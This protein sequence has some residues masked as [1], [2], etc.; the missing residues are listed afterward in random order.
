ML[1]KVVDQKRK[2]AE[3]GELMEKLKSVQLNEETLAKMTSISSVQTKGLKR[4]AQEEEWLRRLGREEGV[5]EVVV[6]EARKAVEGAKPVKRRKLE[7][8]LPKSGPEVLGFGE[9]SSSSEEEEYEK[10]EDDDTE[11]AESDDEAE[12]T[13]QEEEPEEGAKETKKEPDS[14]ASLPARPFPAIPEGHVLVRRTPEV[15][16]GR[17]KLPILGEEH[18]VMEAVNHNPVVILAGETGSG[19]TTQVPQFLYEAGY[20]EGGRMIGVTEPRR[21][22]AMAMARRVGEEMGMTEAVSYQVRFEGNTTEKTRIKF[23]TDGVLLRE[24]SR[25]FSLRRYSVI[26]IDEAHERSVFTDILLGSLSRVVR[27]RERRP[28]LGG[29]LRIVVMSAT[30]RVE[31]FCRVGLFR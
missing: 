7:R 10:E 11:E 9:S 19:K 3:R 2:K 5:D 17:E 14:K 13:A 21:V 31:D 4:H 30:L 23:M 15:Q 22:A 28:E 6:Q 18:A 29:P 27:Q 16:S 12:E 26:V 20:A 25:D 24:M 1:Q 8:I